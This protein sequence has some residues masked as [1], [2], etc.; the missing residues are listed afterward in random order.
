MDTVTLIIGF[1][2]GLA[3]GIGLCVWL[4]LEMLNKSRLMR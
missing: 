4:A 3:V 1:S 2:I